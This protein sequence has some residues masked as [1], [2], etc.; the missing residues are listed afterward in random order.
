MSSSLTLP[1]S[2]EEFYGVFGRYNVAVWPAQVL[3]VLLALACVAALSFLPNLARRIPL[4]LAGLWTWMGVAYHFAFFSVINPAAWAFG[5]MCLAA[6]AAFA[7][8]GARGK[9]VFH[10]LAGWRGTAGAALIA[11]A[12]IGYPV[13][14]TL[15]G[16]AY[17]RSP[18]FGLP[19]PTTIFTLGVLLFAVRPAPRVVF[20][21]P[22]LWSAIG[23]LA[24]FS[25]GV[26]QDI[27]L[28]VAAAVVVPALASN[29]PSKGEV[30]CRSSSLS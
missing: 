27:G 14:G 11:Y 13:L 12:L 15:L 19:C 9:L 21:V 3:L 2:T 5:A 20:V 25:L 22:L 4:V 26:R 1:F 24:A 28:L 30:S 8:E 16:S 29:T 10:W 6:A 17:P 23:S 7:W 18:T